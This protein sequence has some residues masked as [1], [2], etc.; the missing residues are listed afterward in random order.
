M[1]SLTGNFRSKMF[2][3]SNNQDIIVHIE[4][5]NQICMYFIIIM[6]GVEAVRGIY[7]S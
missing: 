4:V 1:W 6:K 5:M 2:F 3:G 7:F